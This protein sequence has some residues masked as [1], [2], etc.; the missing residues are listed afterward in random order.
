MFAVFAL[1][2]GFVCPRRI[3]SSHAGPAE[4]CASD[5]KRLTNVGEERRL[6]GTRH[7]KECAYSHDPAGPSF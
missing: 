7:A 3:D 5:A 1:V 4:Q 6:P 2:T